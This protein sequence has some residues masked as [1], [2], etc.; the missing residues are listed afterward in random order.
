MIEELIF[1]AAVPKTQ[2]HVLPLFNILTGVLFIVPSY[3]KPR[4]NDLSLMTHNMQRLGSLLFFYSRKS[5][6]PRM[7]TAT[8]L[9]N[10]RS[11]LYVT[12]SKFSSIAHRSTTSCIV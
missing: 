2:Q 11:F 4:N 7:M 5:N 9:V 1:F 8:L 12:G 10:L 3:D 6:T